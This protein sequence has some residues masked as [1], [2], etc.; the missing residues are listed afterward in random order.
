[1]SRLGTARIT[2]S[3]STA[4]SAVGSANT[5]PRSSIALTTAAVTAFGR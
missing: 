4:S 1:M 5:V 2:F 3:A